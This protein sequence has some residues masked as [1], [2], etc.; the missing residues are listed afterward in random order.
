M[1]HKYVQAKM[2]IPYGTIVK[3]NDLTSS[4]GETLN[5][6]HALVCD[7]ANRVKGDLRYP[8]LIYALCNNDGKDEIIK[9]Q[10]V[11]KEN[12]KSIKAEN[13]FPLE[14]QKHELLIQATLEQMQLSMQTNQMPDVL[15]FIEA[16][17]ERWP[18]GGGKHIGIPMTYIELLYYHLRDSVKAFEVV[19]NIMEFMNL[20]VLQ[21]QV[22]YT[23]LAMYGELCLSCG[24]EEYLGEAL[25]NALKIDTS[26]DQ[27]RSMANRVLQS[28]YEYT[29]DKNQSDLMMKNKEMF[30]IQV[31]SAEKLYELNPFMDNLYNLGASHCLRGDFLKGAKCYRRAM[32]MIENGTN[33][34]GSP[35]IEV[36]RQY[37]IEAQMQCPGMPLENYHIV[38]SENCVAKCVRREDMD[39]FHGWLEKNPNGSYRFNIQ[40]NAT[41]PGDSALFEFK[42]L[43]SSEND[44]KYFSREFLDSL[45]Q[46]G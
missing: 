22:Y 46:Q 1:H 7:D 5:G 12:A 32:D 34:S 38:Q 21:P 19:N 9:D 27:S 24:A 14:D 25:E 23:F 4:V 40:F 3:I 16:V 42:T 45:R 39:K 17:C 35:S 41:S 33:P 2:D 8:V 13:L 36:R 26:T 29:S 37:L 30:D 6:A 18:D 20:D 43:P 28:I 10:L 15:P 31:R 11:T 44:P